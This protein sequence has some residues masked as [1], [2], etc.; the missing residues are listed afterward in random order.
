MAKCKALTGSAV[1]GLNTCIVRC[2]GASVRASD[3]RFT[4]PEFES[5][6]NII[7]YIVALG[8]LLTRV[9]LYHQAV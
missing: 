3:L 4:G 6:L 2:R 5:W 9:C 7:D 8:K 1:K